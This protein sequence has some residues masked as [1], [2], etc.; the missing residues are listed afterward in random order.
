MVNASG[1]GFSSSLPNNM[2][3][4]RL[5]NEKQ[6]SYS[7]SAVNNYS[8][9]LSNNVSS[10]SNS[11]HNNIT[12]N[13]IPANLKKNFHSH[14]AGVGAFSHIPR[15]LLKSGLISDKPEESDLSED[16]R[17]PDPHGEETETAPEA[18]GEEE[19]VTR[20]IW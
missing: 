19:S 11:L 4:S 16:D 6:I 5:N 10:T 8:S 9:T 3:S 15:G 18:E 2:N 17:L 13:A 7:S 1:I 20:C 12:N 14:G